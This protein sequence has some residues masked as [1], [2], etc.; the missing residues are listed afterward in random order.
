M[1]QAHRPP[2][3]G[4]GDPA[5]GRV[6]VRRLPERG[7]Y[8][9]EDV[10]AI[11]DEG[12]VCHVGFVGPDGPVVIPTAYGRLGD[13]LYLHGASANAML[14]NAAAGGQLCIT[15]TLVDGLVLARSAF[16]HSINY[17]SV[18]VYGIGEEVTEADEKRQ[19]LAAIVEHLVPGRGTDARPPTDSELRATRVVRVPLGESSA[20]VRA[21]GPKDDEED[22]ALPVWAGELPILSATGLPIAADDLRSGLRPPGYVTSYRR[23][24]SDPSVPCRART[25]SHPPDPPDRSRDGPA[26]PPPPPGAPA[27]SVRATLLVDHSGVG[28]REEEVFV[29]RVRPSDQVGRLTIR[30]ANLQHLAVPVGLA[31]PA[32]TDQDPI[33]DIGVHGGSLRRTVCPH[34]M[35]N[36]TPDPIKHGWWTVSAM[37]NRHRETGRASA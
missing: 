33:P 32:P 28:A 11:L 3:A 9:R 22:L 35:V 21:G 37:R 7:R 12:F 5:S 26:R 19:A 6:R 8:R 17:R 15:V 36:R 27:D 10:D 29:A 34:P 25:P 1:A 2:E 31:H 18:V 23:G 16:H 30:V 20:K 4:P 14:R 24:G 13:Q